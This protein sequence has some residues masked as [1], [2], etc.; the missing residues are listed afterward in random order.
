MT[1]IRQI[2]SQQV[3]SVRPNDSVAKA[4]EILTQER[5]GSLSVVDDKGALVGMV[6]ELALIDVV[7]DRGVS[8]AEVSSYVDKDVPFVQP[9]EG[10]SRAGQLFALYSFRRLPVVEGGKLVGMVTCRD[11]MNHALRTREV[12]AEPLLE[13]IPSLA[14]LS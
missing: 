9:D 7:F 10:L 4:I 11:L 14:P 1:T 2:M 13:L 12:L 6:S 8:D 5:A 3:V